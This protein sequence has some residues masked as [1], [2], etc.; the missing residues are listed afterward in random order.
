[1]RRSAGVPMAQLAHIV[2][3]AARTPVG[4]R[5]AP[6]AA[7]VRA[8]VCRLQEHPFFVDAWGEPVACGRDA[9]LDPAMSGARRLGA[10]ARGAFDE[11]ASKLATAP[12][13]TNV[14]VLIALPEP[15][16]GHDAT[17]DAGLQ[18]LLASERI[19]GLAKTTIRCVGRGHAG[20][21]LGLEQALAMISGGVS[22]LCIVGGVDSYLEGNTLDWLEENRRLACPKARG[23]FPPGEAAAFLVLASPGLRRQYRLPSLG[24]LRAVGRANEP[25]AADPTQELQ[26]LGF[27]AAFSQL[28]SAVPNAAFED[29]YCDINGERSRTTDLAFAVLRKPELFPAG[30]QILSFADRFGDIGAATAAL[31]CVLAVEGWRNQWSQVRAAM[32]CGASWSGDRGAALLEQGQ[33]N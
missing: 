1:M 7:A 11:L 28:A 5:A 2:A 8:S 22:E 17:E 4:L 10:L 21:F 13:P 3:V 32:V 14:P 19:T 12:H 6:T 23:G 27:A 33:A 29:V 18:S 30:N 15:R 26:G 31:H 9:R 16:P 25:R 24:V 20:A